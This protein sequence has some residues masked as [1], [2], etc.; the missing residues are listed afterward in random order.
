MIRRNWLTVVF[1]VHL[2]KPLAVDDFLREWFI[3]GMRDSKIL[4][5][6]TICW[7]GNFIGGSCDENSI[8]LKTHYKE[9][10]TS[11]TYRFRSGNKGHSV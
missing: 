10:Y 9:Q 11:T 6:A 7:R 8:R 3:K 1:F 4:E 5:I 2:V